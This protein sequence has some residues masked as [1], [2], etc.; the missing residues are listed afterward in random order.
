MD[1]KARLNSNSG[2]SILF[3]LIL[4][5][6]CFS[7]LGCGST[8]NEITVSLQLDVAST[9][10][11]PAL[12]DVVF[13]LN[14]PSDP[15]TSVV[16][17]AGCTTSGSASLPAGCG[18][19]AATETFRLNLELVATDIDIT[20]TVR[21]RDSAGSTLFEGTSAAFTNNSATTSVSINVAASS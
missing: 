6:S 11:N 12:D 14:Q 16:F 15:T 9:F 5:V 2:H 21:G 20:L 19:P 8:P 7:G 17:P 4:M 3:L 18:F 13:I 1:S 10:D